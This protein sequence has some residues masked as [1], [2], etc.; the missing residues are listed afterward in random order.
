LADTHMTDT[1]HF[2][3]LS[4]YFMCLPKRPRWASEINER[5][6]GNGEPF[7]VGQCSPQSAR[8]AFAQQSRSSQDKAAIREA[9]ST[10][11]GA[12]HDIVRAPLCGKAAMSD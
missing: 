1:V 12:N 8:S 3:M 10:V 2:R 9:S 7:F 5:G 4:T 6:N 11:I